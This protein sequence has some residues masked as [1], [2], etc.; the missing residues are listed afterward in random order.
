MGYNVQITIVYK[1][2]EVNNFPTLTF[3]AIAARRE[4][5]RRVNKMYK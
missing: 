1:L 4:E 2:I 5:R 3:L